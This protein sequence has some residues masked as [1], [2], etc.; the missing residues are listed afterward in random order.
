MFFEERK[1]RKKMNQRLNLG[2]RF[3]KNELKRI[4]GKIKVMKIRMLESLFQWKQRF[5]VIL[6]EN[7]QSQR[8]KLEIFLMMKSYLIKGLRGLW[9]KEEGFFKVVKVWM[10]IQV[11][12]KRLQKKRLK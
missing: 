6:M 10:K 9:K 5:Q 12:N 11:K 7:V 1:V 4:M 2:M 3:L 8:L